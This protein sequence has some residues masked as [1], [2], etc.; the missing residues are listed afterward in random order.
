VPG[1]RLADLERR[2]IRGVLARVGGRVNGKGG[3]AE[4]PGIQP[5]PLRHRMRKL[6]TAFGRRAKVAR[7][8]KAL[9][10]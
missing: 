6:G 9:G 5:N 7:K 10:G 4:L 2:P 8:G 1:V 3:A